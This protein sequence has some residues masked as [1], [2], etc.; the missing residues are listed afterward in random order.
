MDNHLPRSYTDVIRIKSIVRLNAMSDTQQ[1]VAP[2]FGTF[3]DLMDEYS[4]DLQL[5]GKS[6]AKEIKRIFE[7][8]VTAH[9]PELVTKPAREITYSDIVVILTRLLNS[10]PSKRGINNSTPT[11]DSN[12]R[13][14]TNTLHTYLR[15]A[16]K[17]A[18]CFE[19]CIDGEPVVPN[20]FALISNP[21]EAVRALD[22]V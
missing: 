22:E 21:A 13:S 1:A 4:L 7:I 12:M 16:F 11:K 5:R 20:R 17:K 14:T 3:Q 2:A 18:K 8:H 15:A 19:A 6:K 10:K 9:F